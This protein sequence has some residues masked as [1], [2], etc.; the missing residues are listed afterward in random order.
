MQSVTWKI[1]QGQSKLWPEWKFTVDHRKH[2]PCGKTCTDQMCKMRPGAQIQFKF[3]L[4]LKVNLKWKF[5]ST[6]HTS[7]PQLQSTDGPFT[8]LTLDKSI[9]T[10]T[11][12]LSI[13]LWGMFY[14]RFHL[15]WGIKC[16]DRSPKSFWICNRQ[17]KTHAPW[18]E[19]QLR[20]L[21]VHICLYS[22]NCI[23]PYTCLKRKLCAKAILFFS[24]VHR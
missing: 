24:L 20:C 5:S 1:T 12:T 6:T 22:V 21:C 2:F 13:S 18:G 7:D 4:T 9:Y 23:H 16:V 17:D 15:L 11:E 10:N 14:V 19:T 8:C 3:K